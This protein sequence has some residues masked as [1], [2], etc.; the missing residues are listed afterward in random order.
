M[1]T[2]ATTS[3]KKALFT[4]AKSSGVCLLFAVVAFL[5]TNFIRLRRWYAHCRLN[6]M[7]PPNSTS[8]VRSRDIK[9][10]LA[11]AT[12]TEAVT[13]LRFPG[14]CASTA[15]P[16]HRCSSRGEE[17]GNVSWEEARLSPRQMNL[18]FSPSYTSGTPT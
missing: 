11:A 1:V 17:V 2:T 5:L 9:I 13:L 8:C 14:S 7:W 18:L 15:V 4:A 6:S 10:P 3:S 12:T 16:V